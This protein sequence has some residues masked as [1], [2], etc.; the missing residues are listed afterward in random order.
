MATITIVQVGRACAWVDV[1]QSAQGFRAS[2][3]WHTGNSGAR[4]LLGEAHPTSEEAVAAQVEE[5]LAHLV[6]NNRETDL[7]A[8][9]KAW[10]NAQKA[11]KQMELI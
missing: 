11:P 4:H 3:S 2:Y 10:L 6:R 7:A 1:V 8:R 9:V 5:M